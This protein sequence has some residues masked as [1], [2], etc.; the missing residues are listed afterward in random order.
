MTDRFTIEKASPGDGHQIARLV[1]RSLPVRLRP[2][3][4][5][6]S[7]GAGPYVD[8]ILRGGSRHEAHEFF[9]LRQGVTPVGLAAFRQLDGQAFLN[10]LYLAP[11]LRG[12]GLGARLLETAARRRLRHHPAEKISLDVF[13]GAQ[14][15]EAWYERLGFSER[16]QRGWWLRAPRRPIAASPRHSCSGFST[17]VIS[18]A[19]GRRYQVG[20]LHTPYFRLTDPRAAEDHELHRSLAALDPPSALLLIAPG[21]V[22]PR[23]W[24][25]IA[26]SRRLECNAAALLDRLAAA[27]KEAA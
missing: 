22:A 26:V 10:H 5:W 2:L 24:K 25:K 8:A 16:S 3:T 12:R 11:E 7:P 14:P 9:L 27:A 21:D 23:G 4:I 19:A 17:F 15:A 6:E 20:R 13:A 1:C 18:T